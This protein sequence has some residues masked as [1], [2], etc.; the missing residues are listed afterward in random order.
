[1]AGS[2]NPSGSTS[3]TTNSQSTSTSSFSWFKATG[4]LFSFLSTSPSSSST[5][6]SNSSTP[7]PSSSPQQSH[8][9][10]S[11]G[12][13]K[14]S[15]SVSSSHHGSSTS[16]SSSGSLNNANGSPQ[17]DRS[18]GSKG[19]ARRRGQTTT[20]TTTNTNGGKIGGGLGGLLMGERTQSMDRPVMRR[21]P[22]PQASRAPSPLVPKQSISNMNSRGPSPLPPPVSNQRS[23]SPLTTGGYHSL[24]RTQSLSHQAATPLASRSASPAPSVSSTLAAERLA[25]LSDAQVAD[26]AAQVTAELYRRKLGFATPMGVLLSFYEKVSGGQV[27]PTPNT[28]NRL[29]GMSHEQFRLLAAD[30]DAEAVRRD[31]PGVDIF[32]VG[33]GRTLSGGVGGSGGNGGGNTGMVRSLTMG[34]SGSLSSLNAQNGGN[35]G[36]GNG[37]FGRFGPGNSA[38][39]E[40]IAAANAH[41][42]STN[43]SGLVSTSSSSASLSSLER[44]NSF[45]NSGAT[46]GLPTRLIPVG[47]GPIAASTL[48]GSGSANGATGNVAGSPPSPTSVGFINGGGSGLNG[49]VGDDGGSGNGNGMDVNNDDRTMGRSR[50]A[51]L[52]DDIFFGMVEDLKR[53]IERRRDGGGSSGTGSLRRLKRMGVAVAVSGNEDGSDGEGE[54]D[55]EGDDEGLVMKVKKVGSVEEIKAGGGGSLKMEKSP[56]FSDSVFAAVAAASGIGK[57]VEFGDGK[58]KEKDGGTNSATLKSVSSSGGSDEGAKKD[59]NGNGKV[60]NGNANELGRNGSISSVTK[61]STGRSGSVGHK[62]GDLLMRGGS[63]N[64]KYEDGVLIEKEELYRSLSYNDLVLVWEDAQLEMVRRAKGGVVPC[65]NVVVDANGGSNEVPGSVVGDSGKEKEKDGSGA[66]SPTRRRAN[67]NAAAASQPTPPQQQ[68]AQQQQAQQQPEPANVTAWRSRIAKLTDDQLAEV[69]ADVYDE[70]SRR[71]NKDAPFLP[72]RGDLS[73]KRNEARKELSRLPSRELKTLWGIIQE[74]LKKRRL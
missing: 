63:V 11:H 45:S 71:K 4:K 42:G 10:D 28:S 69:T 40:A 54:G 16:L 48:A 18:K 1:M 55:G 8:N 3:T 68:A 66:S 67:L 65:A 47:A 6:S 52:R 22:S 53:E 12:L 15:F 60:S 27:G 29:S 5:T 43:G 25:R 58:E 17:M 74:N 24:D 7:S 23:Q 36:S 51:Q 73:P 49:V 14:R 21:P 64:R 57:A 34:S 38:A 26:L 50:M 56:S 13:G 44:S 33:R 32:G 35:Q 39:A 19:S 20:T 41:G 31:I 9:T 2:S 70:I 46:G 59:A 72:P 62:R 37:T 61:N 30:L